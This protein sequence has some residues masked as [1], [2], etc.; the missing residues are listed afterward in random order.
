MRCYFEQV[1]AFHV[2]I[3]CSSKHKRLWPFLMAWH[4][5]NYIFEKSLPMQRLTWVTAVS[6]VFFNLRRLDWRRVWMISLW[7]VPNEE[8]HWLKSFFFLFYLKWGWIIWLKDSFKQFH[9]SE[10]WWLPFTSPISL[11][12]QSCFIVWWFI[13][14]I[15]F[16]CSLSIFLLS[17][18]FIYINI[19]INGN[20]QKALKRFC[21]AD[22]CSLVTGSTTFYRKEK[23]I[24]CC[25]PEMVEPI[26][27][28]H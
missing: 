13:Y 22:F 10:L 25:L 23:K 7:F 2:S 14:I 28:I 5:S 26:S 6:D 9:H 1:A 24:C 17:F 18:S 15:F 20:L 16:S 8:D 3:D 11:S 21:R 27:P 19:Y 12:Q 4:H